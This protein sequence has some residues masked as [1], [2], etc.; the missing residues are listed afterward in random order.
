MSMLLSHT[1]DQT[2]CCSPQVPDPTGILKPGEVFVN[3]S[4][5]CRCCCR[6]KYCSKQGLCMHEDSAAAK[7]AV[8]PKQR[9]IG[10]LKDVKVISF[11]NPSYHPGQWWAG[12]E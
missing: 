7:G 2:P 3:I 9:A 12:L 4:G 1:C 11:R 6:T 10:L 8:E 5:T